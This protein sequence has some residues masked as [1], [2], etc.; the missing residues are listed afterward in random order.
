MR[1]MSDDSG[2]IPWQPSTWRE[3]V[4][5]DADFK[6]TLSRILNET[7]LGEI[8]N[9]MN[10]SK[11]L[12]FGGRGHIIGLAIFCAIDTLASYFTFNKAVGKRYKN[13]IKGYFPEPYKSY[14]K[15][16]YDFYRNEMTHSWNLFSVAIQYEGTKITD[17]GMT[18]GLIDIY[19]ALA[20]ALNE[21]LK[22][23]DK[24]SKIRESCLNRY[25]TLRKSSRP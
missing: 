24:D 25:N 11:K 6:H 19:K 14:S 15:A 2:F 22:A 10:D 13:F 16:I 17:S 1:Y 20:S 9:V 5:A 8:K 4:S 3:H 18:I 12:K 23:Y 7:I 21:A